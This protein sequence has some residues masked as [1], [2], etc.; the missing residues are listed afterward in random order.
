MNWAESNEYNSNGCPSV[1]V[2]VDLK[3]YVLSWSVPFCF[4]SSFIQISFTHSVTA[5]VL[6]SINRLQTSSLCLRPHIISSHFCLPWIR[7]LV[8]VCILEGNRKGWS[9]KNRFNFCCLIVLTYTHTANAPFRSDRS[10]SATKLRMCLESNRYG[11]VATVSDAAAAADWQKWQKFGTS[12]LFLV[13][14]I[15]LWPTRPVPTASGAVVFPCLDVFERVYYFFRRY[16][17]EYTFQRFE[18]N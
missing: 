5:T 17:S 12:F 8:C 6:S 10:S 9:W 11:N 2:M 15:F 16:L 18:G 14:L 1:V 7:R 4:F 13:L 3:G